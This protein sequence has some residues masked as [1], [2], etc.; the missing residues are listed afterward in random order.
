MTSLAPSRSPRAL[1]GTTCRLL[2]LGTLAD[3]SR[4]AWRELAASAAE[5]NPFFELTFVEPAWQ[6]LRP[7]GVALLVVERGGDW[8]ACMPVERLGRSTVLLRAWRNPYC[9]LATPLVRREALADGA[10]GL[11][12]TLHRRASALALKWID[13]DGPVAA[14]LRDAAAARGLVTAWE[15]RFERAVL[16]T[17]AGV[18]RQPLSSHRLRELRRRERRLAEAAGAPLTTTERAADP[19]DLARFLELEAAGWKGRDRTALAAREGDRRFFTAMASDFAAEGRFH[20][21][22]LDAGDMTLAMSCELRA[23]DAVF[24]FKSAF[25]ER[26]HKGAPGVQLMHE[27]VDVFAA[28]PTVSLL[29]SCSDAGNSLVNELLPSRRVLTSSVLTGAGLPARVVTNAVRVEREL[30][31]RHEAARRRRS[32]TAA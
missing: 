17:G 7:R 9:F 25:D 3:A 4:E 31:A 30:R 13:A 12:S 26:F 24:G 23:G 10:D 5:P 27:T 16:R 20:L 21:R 28:D 2:P 29:D 22:S 1:H 8:L 14:A 15:D 6:H 11:L 19:A 32:V 18:S